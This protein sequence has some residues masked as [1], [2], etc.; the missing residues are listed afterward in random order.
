MKTIV[1][2][3]DF[4]GISRNAAEYAA[5]LSSVIG[6]HL[7]LFHTCI[8][9]QSFSEVPAPALS[10]SGLKEE[11]EKQMAILKDRLDFRTGGR[12]KIDTEIREG[13]V[14]SELDRYCASIP[15]Y[16]VVMGAESA[17]AFERFL[18]GGK[19]LSAM[20]QLSWPLIIIPPDV[21][22]SSL[23]KIGL[24]C[25]LKNVAESLPVREIESMVNEFNAELHVLHANKD[26]GDTFSDDQ[27]AQTEWLRDLIGQ[28]KPK[29]HFIKDADTE[30]AITDFA[31]QNGIDLLIIIPKN[32]GLGGK[33][34]HQ[35]L[36]KKLVL[37][38]H[39]P[40]MAIHE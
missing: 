4:S 10:L 22:F 12:I 35:S 34:F 30:K 36:S 19:T 2:P 13:N 20:K 28:L 1:V 33:I 31:E 14:I 18:F 23:R 3:V 40:V 38:A 39:T 6:T 37:H 17:G 21:K 24:A 9:P 7:T 26:S 8:I 11:A 16:A 27:I 25:D 5:D 29:Y 15:V 32:H